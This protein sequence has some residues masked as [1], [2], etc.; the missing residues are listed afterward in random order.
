MNEYA[1]KHLSKHLK[2]NSI[3]Y[4]IKPKLLYLFLILF[5]LGG[6]NRAEAYMDDFCCPEFYI[7]G[8][9]QIRHITFERKFGGNMFKKNYPQPNFYIGLKGN[10][11]IG[12]EV[13]YEF[14][15]SHTRSVSVTAQDFLLG[16]QYPFTVRQN[17]IA[18]FKGFHST[19]VGFLPVCDID[20][21]KV[22]VGIGI[23]N[24]RIK[25]ESK[26]THLDEEPQPVL[27]VRLMESKY[28]L[29]L[30]TGLQYMITDHFGVRANIRWENTA[31]IKHISPIRQFSPSTAKANNSIVYGLGLLVQF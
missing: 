29:R 3:Q 22:L 4:F 11:Y 23:V 1:I 2:T 13:G 28:V 6:V 5:S 9:A 31:K 24:F 30:M 10:E 17:V 26:L 12:L 20:C 19:L 27:G 15:R 21:L 8:D 18:R 14:S 25:L 7:G 16:D